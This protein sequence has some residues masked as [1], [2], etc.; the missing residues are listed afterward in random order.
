MLLTSRIINR[1]I[2]MLEF[3]SRTAILTYGPP[4]A[5]MKKS[6][7]MRMLKWMCAMTRIVQIRKAYIML[8]YHQKI[9]LTSFGTP[10]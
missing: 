2:Y 5:R 7:E 10:L 6:A 3:F 8:V 9:S 1:I 4:N